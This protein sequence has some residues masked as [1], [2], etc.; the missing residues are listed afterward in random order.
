MSKVEVLV[1]KGFITPDWAEILEEPLTYFYNSI[2]PVIKESKVQVYPDGKNIF[3]AFNEC[4]YKDVKVVILGMDPYFDGSA[5]GLAFDNAIPTKKFSR[6]LSMICKELERDL[7]ENYVEMLTSNDFRSN[8]ILG[9]L[10]SQGVLLLNTALTVEHGKAG[11]HIELWKPFTDA[12]IRKLQEKDNIVWILWGNYAKA[13]KELITNSTH[14]IV[15]GCH[16]VARGK[17]AKFL[18]GKYF[19]KTNTHLTKM[20][21]KTIN[22]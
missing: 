4:P 7:G 10:P 12:V 9:H 16:P 21:L 8:S 13:Y 1:E 11:S 22:W 19:S 17:H 18:G 6:S 15:E 20:G 3:R 2:V 14:K 5:T